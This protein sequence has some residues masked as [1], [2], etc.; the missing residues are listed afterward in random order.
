MS[1]RCSPRA[2]AWRCQE[3][4]AVSTLGRKARVSSL[5]CRRWTCPTCAARLLKRE[6]ARCLAGLR[7][8]RPVWMVTVTAA[9]HD[10]I[11]SSFRLAPR[12]WASLMERLR[13][14]WPAASVEYFRVVE[15]QRRGH[16]HIHALVSCPPIPPSVLRQLAV[17]AGFGP[18][19]HVR[20]SR[21]GDTAYITKQLANDAFAQSAA[22]GLPRP[23]WF[24]PVTTSRGWAPAFRVI[25]DEWRIT[26]WDAPWAI[27]HVP[28]TLLVRCLEAAG[29]AV[30]YSGP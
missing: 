6:Q 17:S 5:R 26:G 30:A 13:R 25:R 11:T 19:T 2:R 27:F 29:Y 14:R 21:P 23:K 7:A 9:P 16:A 28:A 4:S 18:Q 15:R 12:R 22:A 1:Y 3:A 8:S 24:R 10:T 20:R